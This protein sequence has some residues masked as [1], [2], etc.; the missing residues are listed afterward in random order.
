MK[1]YSFHKAARK[2]KQTGAK[3]NTLITTS[4]T[5]IRK[6]SAKVYFFL[7]DSK[8]LHTCGIEKMLHGAKKKKKKPIR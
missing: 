7:L 1:E 4:P 3:T 5:H 2:F 6:N 8:K